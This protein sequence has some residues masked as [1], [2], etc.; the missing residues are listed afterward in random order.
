MYVSKPQEVEWLKPQQ[1]DKNNSAMV[2]VVCSREGLLT[3]GTAYWSLKKLASKVA[4]KS[5]HEKS[6]ESSRMRSANCRIEKGNRP[7]KSL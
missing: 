4:G 6:T 2:S 3:N 1:G 7:D 5:S